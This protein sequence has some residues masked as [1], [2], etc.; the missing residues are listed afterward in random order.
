MGVKCL[1]FDEI[2]RFLCIYVDKWGKISVL[3]WFLMNLYENL[4]IFMLKINSRWEGENSPENHHLG[5]LWG[6]NGWNSMNSV[7][8]YV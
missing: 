7:G 4:W 6:Q 2:S 1:N 8:F 3:R 5:N